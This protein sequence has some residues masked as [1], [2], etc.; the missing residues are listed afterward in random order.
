MNPVADHGG[1]L[2]NKVHDQKELI[3]VRLSLHVAEGV[4]TAPLIPEANDARPQIDRRQIA[5]TET[6][7]GKCEKQ[8]VSDV[9]LLR[10]VA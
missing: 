1:C 9:G 5:G 10:A 6:D 3:A 8:G 2:S 7:L 4:S